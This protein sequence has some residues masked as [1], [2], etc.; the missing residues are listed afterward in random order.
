MSKLKT[1]RESI[2]KLGNKL[3]NALGGL[4]SGFD[5]KVES[6]A[7]GDSVQKLTNSINNKI[8]SLTSYVAPK[9]TN[10]AGDDLRNIIGQKLEEEETKDEFVEFE[11]P[12]L[13]V[14]ID[15]INVQPKK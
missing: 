8:G 14:E 2:V 1:P 10:M 3:E 5:A 11:D 13:P 9:T 12:S 7:Q 6:F 15:E 4:G